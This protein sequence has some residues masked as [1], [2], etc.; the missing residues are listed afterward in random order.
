MLLAID[1][2]NT[3]T[4]FGLFTADTPMP[5]AIW[6]LT[7]RRDRTADEWFALL[8][9]L[10][11][12]AAVPLDSIDGA[13]LSSVVP[14]IGDALIRTTRE[15][16][17]VEPLIVGPELDLGISVR[18]DA[19][20]E[21][22]TDRIANCV[23][24]FAR[25]GGP[26]VVVDLGTATKIEAITGG[27]DYLGGV[28]APGIGLTLDALATRAARLYAVELKRPTA[29]IGGNTIAAV[30]AGVVEGHLAMIEG[31]VARMRNQLGG[32]RNIVL[33]GGYSHVFADARSVFT[34]FVPTLTLEGLHL[35]YR[36]NR[37]W[38]A[39]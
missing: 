28:I 8:A 24:A 29:A 11:V 18:T 17:S 4:V 9:P 20:N 23:A 36:R 22:G 39:R 5:S 32:A 33:T 38:G 37:E 26:T 6:R 16:F 1:A 19:P 7:S 15:R 12:A 2:G 35:I 14:A 10:F 21:T 3:N 30:Q 31:L 34:D 27:G 13:V 25:F